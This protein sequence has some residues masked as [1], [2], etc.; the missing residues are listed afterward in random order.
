[1]DAWSGQDVA[2]SIWGL[3]RAGYVPHGEWLSAFIGAATQALPS[4]R[5]SHVAVTLWSL[6]RLGLVSVGH[7]GWLV[8][9]VVCIAVHLSQHCSPLILQ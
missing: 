3:A 9:R 2:N 1:M 5:G 8:S 6:A 4:M 7:W